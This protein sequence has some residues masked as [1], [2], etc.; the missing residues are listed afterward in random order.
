MYSCVSCPIMYSC[1]VMLILEN[2]SQ[3][4]CRPAV[5]RNKDG[6]KNTKKER[7][8]AKSKHCIFPYK[9][10]RIQLCVASASKFTFFAASK[11]GQL[12]AAVVL[13][14]AADVFRYQRAETRH[15]LRVELGFEVSVWSEICCSPL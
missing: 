13:F 14:T 1:H 11:S 10:I 12:S 2:I 8:A 6:F 15:L 5:Y 9:H 7:E 3:Y 4:I